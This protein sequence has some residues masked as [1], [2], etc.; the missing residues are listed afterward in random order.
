MSSRTERREELAHA[1]RQAF[2]RH[3]LANGLMNQAV[4]ERLGLHLTDLTTMLI[5]SDAG[6]LAASQIA[7]ATGLTSGAVTGVI[8]RL[9]KAG[10]VAREGDPE[11][12]RRVVVRA[13]PERVQQGDALYRPLVEAGDARMAQASEDQMAFMAGFLNGSAELLEQ[14]AARLRQGRAGEP[15]LEASLTAPLGKRTSARLAVRGGASQITIKGGAPAG[16]LYQ[17]EFEGRT[18]R[19]QLD[20]DAVQVS[21]ARPRLFEARG[22]RGVLALAKGPEWD[23]QIRGGGARLRLELEDLSVSGVELTGGVSDIA[24]A[25][26][27]PVGRRRVRITGGASTL[28]LSRPAGVAVRLQLTGGA[29]KVVFDAQR[30]G[31]AG[32]ETRLESDGFA[33]AADAWEIEVSGGA[34][35]LTV[36]SA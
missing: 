9:E 21:F 16:R 30:L 7:E 25:L 11:D 14:H 26:P 3:N 8:D 36:A 4:A 15:E 33:E 22:Q 10:F 28:T 35:A 5:L 2:R 32:G 27:R 6:P 12:R 23:V 1:I 18:P 19:I 13:V 29:A 17:A 20:G 31:A 34:S 24:V